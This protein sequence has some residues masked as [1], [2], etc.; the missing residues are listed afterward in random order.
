MFPNGST[1]LA[2]KAIG[3]WLPHDS[4]VYIHVAKV[5][6]NKRIKVEAWR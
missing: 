6:V 5:G 3:R 1:F 4:S 2:E